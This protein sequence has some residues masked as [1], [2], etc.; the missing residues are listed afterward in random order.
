MIAEVQ[1]NRSERREGKEEYEPSRHRIYI[2]RSNG[3]V[4]TVGQTSSH[5]VTRSFTSWASRTPPKRSHVGCVIGWP[6]FLNERRRQDQDR[7]GGSARRGSR[8][9]TSTLGSTSHWPTGWPPKDAAT[10][11]GGLRP[12]ETYYREAQASGSAWLDSLSRIDG[13]HARERRVWSEFGLLDFDFSAERRALEGPE[14]IGEEERETLDELARLRDSAEENLRRMRQGRPIPASPA[15]R[16]R[17]AVEQLTQLAKERE[18][19]LA[20]VVA[21]TRRRKS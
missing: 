2:I 14:D 11:L 5:W 1:L 4:E 18:E 9:R 20:G 17:I 3:S 6:S 10:V 7:Q 19:L 8:P 21:K 16:A 12:R 15:G 13:L